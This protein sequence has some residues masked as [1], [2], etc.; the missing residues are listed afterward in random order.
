MDLNTK[1]YYKVSTFYSE[2]TIV[3]VYKVKELSIHVDVTGKVSN[4]QYKEKENE[5]EK[6]DTIQWQHVERTT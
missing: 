5:P 4:L 1:S 3:A 6:E 2:D